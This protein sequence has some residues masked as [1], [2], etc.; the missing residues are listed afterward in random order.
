MIPVFDDNPLLQQRQK[1]LQQIR[2]MG[3]D[4][5]PRKFEFTQNIPTVVNA[6]RSKTSAELESEQE[7][8]R[9]CGR[10]IALRG[11][12]KAAFASIAEGGEQIQFYI[13]KD[14]VP[15]ETYALF[16]LLDVGDFVGVSGPLFRTRTGE[17]TIMVK[18]LAFL[19]KGLLP[20]PEKWHGLTDVELRYRQ[21]YV[22]LIVNSEVRRTFVVRSRIIREIRN[23]LD[24]RGYIEVET[25]M[26][27]PIAGGATARP[28]KTY[29]NALDMDF[30]LRI[31]PELYLK[32]LI[33]GGM[34]RVYEINRNFR[35]EGLST[36]HNPEFTMLEFYQAYSDYRDLM[37][38][39]EEMLTQLVEKITGTRE[40][41]FNGRRI[42]FEKWQRLGLK[43]SIVRY[44]DAGR[45][46]APTVQ[47]LSAPESLRRSLHL[48]GVIGPEEASAG[49]LV[50]LLFETVAEEHLID[51]T[52]IYDFPVDLSPLSK[53]KPDDP[54][55]VERFELFI[56]GLE[57]ANAYSE[58]NDPVEQHK[59][60]EEQVRNRQRGDEEAHAM[61]ED[62]I[63]ALGY[64]MPPTAGEGIGVD[65]LTMLLTNSKSIRDVI[66]FPHLRPEHGRPAEE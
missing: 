64:G 35:N 48:Y 66:L 57:V 10:I 27:Q 52:F 32:R 44:W 20:L 17:L 28:F 29:H 1:K 24:R 55:T 16:E 26:M 62:Y 25:P 42:S 38:L 61:D 47:Q 6:N 14:Q 54:S 36:Q 53:T 30:Y 41:E 11:F 15:A 56:G 31:A 60:F 3:V 19:S 63:R 4:P 9:T 21:R 2:E 8:V 18:S 39:T 43:E 12:G 5:Y 46:E 58:L 13:K 45:G 49:A 22:D 34:E 40:L 37:D 59:R 23:F 7:E 33:V 50:G 65:R 51:P